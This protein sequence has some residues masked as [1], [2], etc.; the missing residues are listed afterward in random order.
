MQHFLIN[1]HYSDR[2]DCKD[3]YIIFNLNY[4][5]QDKYEAYYS[6]GTYLMA[7]IDYR[8]LKAWD[9]KLLWYTGFSKLR[10]SDISVE[11]Y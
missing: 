8:G 4:A 6:R 7:G 9:R 11:M 3:A 10:D 5:M 1:H 2:I